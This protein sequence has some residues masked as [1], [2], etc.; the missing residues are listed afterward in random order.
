MR[1]DRL[2]GAE[3]V[4]PPARLPSKS[5]DSDSVESWTPGTEVDRRPKMLDKQNISDEDNPEVL[6]PADSTDAS[7]SGKGL[8][9]FEDL[10]GVLRLKME[11]RLKKRQHDADM[12]SF[13]SDQLLSILSRLVA[14]KSTFIEHAKAIDKHIALSDGVTLASLVND[15]VDFSL[16]VKFS[17]KAVAEKLC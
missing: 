6:R 4:V 3:S 11:E 17:G 1:D 15:R 10:S 8:P 12:C 9:P 5:T 16:P 2:T 7:D 13:K 14:N